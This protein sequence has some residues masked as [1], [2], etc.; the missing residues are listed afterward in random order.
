MVV[1]PQHD[2]EPHLSLL[3]QKLLVLA[4]Y[5]SVDSPRRCEGLNLG[6]GSHQEQQ[7]T[8]LETYDKACP[9]GAHPG[10]SYQQRGSKVQPGGRGRAGDWYSCNI[11]QGG[12]EGHGLS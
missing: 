5:W 4:R 6:W 3:L 12:A 11:G 8:R 9:R 1:D 2:P 7:G 10:D